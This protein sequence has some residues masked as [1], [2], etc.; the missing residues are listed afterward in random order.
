MT[1]P[2]PRTPGRREERTATSRARI[3]DAAVACLVEDGYAG[4]TTLRIQARAGVSRGRL[5][6]H[7]PSR[8]QLLVAASRHLAT[9]RLRGTGAEPACADLPL[10]E[11]IDLAVERL[12]ATFSEPLFWAAV[13]LW[14]A[15][16]TNADL[17]TALLPEEREVGAA[18]RES[19]TRSFGPGA[20]AHP[21][22]PLVRDMIFTSMR[23]V[24]L[25][26]ALDHRD[27]STD[28]HL[29]QWKQLALLL[30]ESDG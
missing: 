22:F 7:F 3:L 9:E 4:A 29:A 6:H 18:V 19:I 15:A 21:H 8:D 20:A 26:Y 12:W 28:P 30:L 11:R 2:A 5:L 13:E 1:T 10:P 25:G 16:R 17:R 14:T 27:P 23:G 24:G